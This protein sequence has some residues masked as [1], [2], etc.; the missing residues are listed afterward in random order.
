[1]VHFDGSKHLLESSLMY[2]C[3]GIGC[4]RKHGGYCGRG[5]LAEVKAGQKSN[6]FLPLSMPIRF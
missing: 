6:N 5:R 1:M 2:L 4:W 3:T